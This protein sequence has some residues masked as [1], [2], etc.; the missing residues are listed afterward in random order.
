MDAVNHVIMQ[1]LIIM[2]KSRHKLPH[3]YYLRALG[4]GGGGG[5][6]TGIPV[7]SILALLSPG[8]TWVQGFWWDKPAPLN[9]TAIWKMWIQ[10]TAIVTFVCHDFFH[11]ITK[12]DCPYHMFSMHKCSLMALSRDTTTYN[13]VPNTDKS[14]YCVRCRLSKRG[15]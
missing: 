14:L 4:R 7:A 13:A 10:S 9:R 3:I 6:R 11:H 1:M 8:S 15:Y 12:R 2:H 5:E